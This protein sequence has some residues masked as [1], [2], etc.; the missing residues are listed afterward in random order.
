M[1]WNNS[2]TLSACITSIATSSIDFGV[3]VHVIGFLDHSTKH[4]NSYINLFP[5]PN[6]ND[7][8]YVDPNLLTSSC[9]YGGLNIVKGVYVSTL[10]AYNPIAFRPCSVHCCC[11]KCYKCCGLHV[12]TI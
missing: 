6:S 1:V 3:L 5:S 9:S 8:P 12:L 10:S 2:V 7:C 4:P 11:C